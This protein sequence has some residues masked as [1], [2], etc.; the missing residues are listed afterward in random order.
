MVRARGLWQVVGVATGCGLW[1]GCEVAMQVVGM[2]ATGWLW[3]GW[4]VVVRISYAAVYK[5]IADVCEVIVRAV[6]MAAARCLGVVA[7]WL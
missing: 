7:G 4:K 6:V 2:M 1:G 3:G 5:P